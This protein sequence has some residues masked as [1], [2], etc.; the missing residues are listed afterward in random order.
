MR[1]ARSN[2][3]PRLNQKQSPDWFDFAQRKEHDLDMVAQHFIDARIS[4]WDEDDKLKWEY[5]REDRYWQTIY[6]SYELF[7]S[8][9]NACAERIMRKL[10]NPSDESTITG[11]TPPPDEPSDEV[12]QKVKER[13]NYRCLCCGQNGQLQVDHINPKYHGGNHSLDNLQTLCVNCNRI[14]GIHKAIN[15]RIH[16]TPLNPSLSLFPGFASG[17]II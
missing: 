1:G 6:N 16:Q 17:S 12:K 13:D 7:K 14:K 5:Q 15:F 2:V 11:E 10:R 4:R 9:Y 8:Q 3:L